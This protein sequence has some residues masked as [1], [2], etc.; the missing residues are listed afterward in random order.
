MIST[1][2]TWYFKQTAMCLIILDLQ[3]GIKYNNTYEC[4]DK[5]IAIL[6]LLRLV[7]YLLTFEFDSRT[8][9]KLLNLLA[10]SA[11]TLFHYCPY[12]P[13]LYK[14]QLLCNNRESETRFRTKI[15]N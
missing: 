1:Q 13:A 11:S 5:L 7:S 14:N 4:T 2:D 3:V 15:V 6:V 8:I 9:V 12:W 10:I